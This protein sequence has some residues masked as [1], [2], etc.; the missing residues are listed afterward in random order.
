MALAAGRYI[1]P[2]RDANRCPMYGSESVE[3]D[4]GGR[5]KDEG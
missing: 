5:M 2:N 4:E 1:A 3:K